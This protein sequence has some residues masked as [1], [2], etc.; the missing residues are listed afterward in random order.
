VTA[1]ARDWS[2]IRLLEPLRTEHGAHFTA[3][4]PEVVSGLA[5]QLRAGDAAAR[6]SF[7]PLCDQHGPHVGLWFYSTPDVR[8]G[9]EHSLR[10]EADRRGWQVLGDDY[11]APTAKYN[12]EH[13]LDRAAALAEVSSDLA[14][15][16]AG[17]GTLT[18]YPETTIAVLHL[19]YLVE[20]IDESKRAAFLFHCWEHWSRE[21]TPEHRVELASQAPDQIERELRTAADARLLESASEWWRRYLAGVRANTTDLAGP[22]LLF[23]HAHL[24]HQRLGIS[25]RTEALAAR[26]V[27]TGLTAES[28]PIPQLQPA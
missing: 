10:A 11:A 21:L 24:T 4:L 20:L 8:T 6:W 18:G 26:I 3:G 5:A 23:D 19:A 22:Y 2:F 17:N 1:V 7:L 28:F 27:R 9:V 12:S 15:A 25:A 13:L 14:L 16:L